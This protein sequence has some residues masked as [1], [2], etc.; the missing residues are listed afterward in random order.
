MWICIAHCR[1]TSNAL[2]ALVRCKQ[3]RFQLF[4]ETVSADGRVSQ[5]LWQWV[6]NRRTC[7][8]ESPSGKNSAGSTIRPEVVG[9]R[10]WDA[11]EMWLW[12]LG[13]RS[14]SGR[15][16]GMLGISDSCEPWRWACTWLARIYGANAAQ[17]AA[18]ATSLGRRLL[19]S[20]TDDTGS[21]IEHSL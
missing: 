14:R 11:A 20:T 13:G 7:H 4:S 6:P 19:L 16:T 10:I 18:A 2:Y 9:W 5:V 1:R 15:P 3:K 12:S 17:C 21:R 8:R